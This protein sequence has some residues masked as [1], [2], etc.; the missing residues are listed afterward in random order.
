VAAAKWS[1]WAGPLFDG[2][3]CSIGYEVVDWI[4]A[5]TC[6]GPGDVQGDAVELDDE[7]FNF[8]IEAYRIDP[9]TVAACTTRRSCPG[10]RP[11]QSELAGHIGVAEAFAPVRFD[12]WKADGQPGA[13]PVRSPLLKCWPPRSRK[14][15]TPSRTSRSSPA[16]G[17][18]TPIRTSTPA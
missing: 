13:R 14:P 9:I 4:Q 3:V 1:H 5:Y 2:H 6:H 16:S 17:A 7:W 8:L 18:R 15:A 12:G 10:R 11:R